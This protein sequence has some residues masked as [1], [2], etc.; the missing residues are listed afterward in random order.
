MF[1]KLTR[2]V[3]N[4][5]CM[6]ALIAACTTGPV[7]R[8]TSP[9]YHIPAGT[10][11]VLHDPLTIPANLAA[12]FIQDGQVKLYRNIDKY[13]PHCKFEVY[14]IKPEDRTIRPDTFVIQRS[15][16][17]ESVQNRQSRFQY[18]SLASLYFGGDGPVFIEMN[19]LM[20]LQSELQP[21]VFRLTCKIW[22][23]A[24]NYNQLTL[25]QVRHA[26]GDLISLHLIGH[27]D[28]TQNPAI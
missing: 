8:E 15:T 7:D 14:T 22:A 1:A 24:P 2:N 18:A 19:R 28:K 21:D 23:T 20:Y 4:L 13:Y 6:T 3:S 17:E 25:N 11:L 10:T 27:A 16:M 26:L 9:D 12:V 5:V